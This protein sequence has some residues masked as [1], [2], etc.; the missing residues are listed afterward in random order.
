MH[1]VSSWVYFHLGVY[2]ILLQKAVFSKSIEM[3]QW[4]RSLAA[5]PEVLSS[6]LSNYMMAHNHL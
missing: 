5:F 4:L 6:I 1:Q 2:A 3:A